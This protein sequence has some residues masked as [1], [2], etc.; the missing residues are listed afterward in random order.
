M[1]D[2][3]QSARED[4]AIAEAIAHA[5]ARSAAEGRLRGLVGE[6]PAD[7]SIPLARIIQQAFVLAAERDDEQETA[8]EVREA[9]TILTEAGPERVWPH[10]DEVILHVLAAYK[11]SGVAFNSIRNIG[12]LL[13]VPYGGSS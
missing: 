8:Q 12:D 1:S 10:H 5:D 2:L 6:N 11:N 7:Q 13:E 4:T 9:V 3:S